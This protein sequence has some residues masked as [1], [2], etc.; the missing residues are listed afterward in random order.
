VGIFNWWL[1]RNVIETESGL[2]KSEGANR[3]PP[4]HQICEIEIK[5]REETDL[6]IVVGDSQMPY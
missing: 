5:E 3:P 1:F 6:I 2:V 4:L